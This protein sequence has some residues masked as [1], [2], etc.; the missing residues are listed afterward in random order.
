MNYSMSRLIIFLLSAATM[1]SASVAAS[2][3][4]NDLDALNDLYAF[5][6]DSALRDG[7]PRGE[8]KGPFVIPSDVYPGTQHTYLV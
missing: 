7:V 3:P 1:G 4:A 6:P 2:Q 5:G 8:V